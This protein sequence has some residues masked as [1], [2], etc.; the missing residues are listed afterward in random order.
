MAKLSSYT[1]L[2]VADDANDVIPIVDVDDPTE[3]PI[4]GTTKKIKIGNLPSGSSLPTGPAGG[5]LGGTYP[6]P[7][8]VSTT[9]AS[10]L[11]VTQG[12]TGDSSLTPY[13]LLAGGVSSSAAVQQVGSA[14]TLG[15]VLT[16][17]GAGALP[18]FQPASGGGSGLTQMPWN[19]LGGWS[20]SSGD[21]GFNFGP[22]APNAGDTWACAI[23][24]DGVVPF[25]S[26]GVYNAAAGSG[27]GNL[28]VVTDSSGNWVAHG[29][30]VDTVFNNATSDLY[31][32]TLNTTVTPPAAQTVYYVVA[33]VVAGNIPP[34]LISIGNQNW[35]ATKS[36]VAFP[37]FMHTNSSS[38][39]TI[40][41]PV[42]FTPFV[43]PTGSVP[44]P[45]FVAL[46]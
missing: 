8:V 31:Y 37:S 17:N 2:L 36:A 20:G 4:T 24:T 30:N 26:V 45:P 38:D 23:V 9:L 33:L 22:S 16:S 6:D 14:G 13:L 19:V 11:P 42:D 12:G 43:A 39:T 29:T 7:Q 25:D 46:K 15:Y 35:I 1:E 32:V 21:P 34:D 40:A 5:D 18:S 44:V 3:S 10:P 41:S 28:L 27:S